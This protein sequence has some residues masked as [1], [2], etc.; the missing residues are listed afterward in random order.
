MKMI[1][2]FFTRTLEARLREELN[3]IQVVLG[4]RQIGKTTGLEQIIRR[5]G[6]ASLMVTAD[7][8]GTPNVEWLTLHWERARHMGKGT[9]LVVDEVQKIDQWQSAIKY[10]YDRDRSERS[11]KVVLLGSA[12]LSIQRGLAESLAG[13]FEVIPAHHWN[14]AECRQAFGW[15]LIEYLM[16]GGYPAPAELIDDIARWQD[17]MREAIIEPVL[18]KDILGLTPV[19]KPALFR[20][21][22]ALTMAHPSHEISLQKILGQLQESGNVTTI[23]HYLNLL[24]GAFLIRTL[25]KYSGSEVRKR[26][27][28]PKIVPLNTALV[29]AFRDPISLE[30][31]T[32]WFGRIFESAVGAALSKSKGNLYYWRQGKFEVDYVL[33][34]EGKI[35]AIEVK[36][37][38]RHQAKG[39]TKFMGNYPNSIPLIITPENCT[40]LL[41]A[42]TVTRDVLA[43]LGVA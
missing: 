5:W 13:R 43:D 42:E 17:F 23:K 25:Q 3:F 24:E 32:E 16:Y 26:G 28:S 4:P 30:T 8:V 29:H 36:S 18:I 34:L 27:S 21:T 2:R 10:L 33:D 9:L 41:E 15:G 12:S 40:H 7:E 11:L 35:Y 1:N 6:G 31:D 38:R 39:L 19:A 14:L 37:G 20:Q 22:F